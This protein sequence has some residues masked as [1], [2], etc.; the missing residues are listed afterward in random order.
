MFEHMDI[1]KSIYE[2]GVEPYTKYLTRTDTNH[3]ACRRKMIGKKTSPKML[4]S[5]YSVPDW[6][7][8]VRVIV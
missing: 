6:L 5:G 1:G 7:E 4:Q 3:S 8:E 2:Y